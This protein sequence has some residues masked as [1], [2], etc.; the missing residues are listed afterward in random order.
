M[1]WQVVG[2]DRAVAVEWGRQEHVRGGEP[3]K[4]RNV[5]A[6]ADRC[7]KRKGFN[8]GNQ[9]SNKIPHAAAGS[10]DDPHMAFD[11]FV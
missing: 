6:G 8:R 1:V 9:I 10:Q 4:G 7:V 5:M 11:V 3:C 2:S